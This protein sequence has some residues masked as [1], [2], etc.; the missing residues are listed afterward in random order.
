MGKPSVSIGVLLSLI[1]VLACGCALF[2]PP[3]EEAFSFCMDTWVSQQWRGARAKETCTEI[4]EALKDLESRVSLYSDTGEIA[5][6]NAAAG[7]SY[8]PV[9]DDVFEILQGSLKVCEETG[10]LFDVT[11]APLSLLWDV[12]GEDPHVPPE[13]AIRAAREKVDYRCLLL[14]EENRAVMLAKEGMQLDLG[15][16]A[17]G[18]AAGRM[19][20]IAEKNGVS[21]FLSIGG[22]MLVVGKK[23]DGSDYLVGL[24]D[25]NGDE[26][27]YFATV[28]ID[29]YTMAT[30]GTYE[31]WFEEDGVRYHHVLDPFTGY[32][33]GQDL[34]SVTVI[35]KDGLL[36]DCLSTAVFLQGSGGLGKALSREDCMVLAVTASN[37]VYASPEFFERL[38]PVPDSGYVFH[39]Q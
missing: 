4:E 5:A 20:E 15:G 30:T 8:V 11:I 28:A 39:T 24:R 38:V 34:V 26:N 19:R 1:L 35:S 37:D 31:R 25:P 2:P 12:T 3:T 33:S 18:Y 14:D 32:P 10:G 13:E 6:V 36:A 17:K 27:D 29:G 22:N 9:S 16:A 23:A 21:G 7:K